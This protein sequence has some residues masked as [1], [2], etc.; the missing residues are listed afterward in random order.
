MHER[1]LGLPVYVAQS[2]TKVFAYLKER[3]WSRIQWWKEKL[4]SRTGKEVLLKDMGC[5]DITKEICEQIST[6]I[7][8]YWWSNQDSDNK[9]HWIK[10]EK[11]TEPKSEGGFGLRDIHTFSTWQCS[12][13]KGGIDF[14]AHTRYVLRC[15]ERNTSQTARSYK[16]NQ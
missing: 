6:M 3:I 7:C 12:Q 8:R 5:F 13:N 4:L 16:Q 2:R 15:S 1:Y 14:T 9:M 10:W 11:L